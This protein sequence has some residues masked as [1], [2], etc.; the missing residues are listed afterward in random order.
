M[1]ARARLTS[2]SVRDTALF[3]TGS[4]AELLAG[5]AWKLTLTALSRYWLPEVVKRDLF[6]FGL[7]HLPLLDGVKAHGLRRGESLQ[8]GFEGGR[9]EVALG[10]ERA[11]L[12]GALDVARAY[13]EFHML[14]GLLCEQVES[15][16]TAATVG[17]VG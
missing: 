4:V 1:M 5:G 12:P 17:A 14:G 16:R 13:L 11:P 2:P 10:E 3:R 7:D 15:Q 8:F 6:L 9:G